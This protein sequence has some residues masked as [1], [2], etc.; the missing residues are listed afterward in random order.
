MIYKP[1][2][3][4]IAADFLSRHPKIMEAGQLDTDSEAPLKESFYNLPAMGGRFP[5]DLTVIAQEQRND[6]QTMSLLQN[7]PEKYE[8]QEYGGSQVVCRKRI[9][10]IG[11]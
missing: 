3:A 5:F 11:K 10:E 4:N 1:G 9:R 2:V 6:E 8:V 7:E